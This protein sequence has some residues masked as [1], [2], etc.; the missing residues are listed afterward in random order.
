MQEQ[1]TIAP[2]DAAGQELADEYVPPAVMDLKTAMLNLRRH[3]RHTGMQKAA[4]RVIRLELRKEENRQSVA[5][6][7]LLID[8][9]A[10]IRGHRID[11]EVQEEAIGAVGNLCFDNGD[12][13]SLAGR[14]NL[15]GDVQKAM[16][17]YRGRSSLQ[18]W[19]AGAIRNICSSNTDNKARAGRMGLLDDLY[20]M[21]KRFS[22]HMGIMHNSVGAVRCLVSNED[23]MIVAGKLG[24]LPCLQSAIRSY[25]AHVGIQMQAVGALRA[26]GGTAE[27][28]T[29]AGSLGMLLDIKGMLFDYAWHEIMVDL[30]AGAIWTLCAV[31][32]S[33]KAEAG[34]LG[35]MADLQAV[36]QQNPDNKDIQ[37]SASMACVTLCF[38]SPA[39]TAE[40]KRIGLMQD[41]QGTLLHHTGRAGMTQ[42]R[43]DDP[44]V[45]LNLA[46]E[47]PL[48]VLPTSETEQIMMLEG[49]GDANSSP[50]GTTGSGSP[51]GRRS[52]SPI[53]SISSSG[54]PTPLLAPRG[55]SSK[56]R[57]HVQ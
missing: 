43:N 39:N 46:D 18:E 7:D 47:K 22:W 51:T 14:L 20:L 54:P 23:N 40:A 52:R 13:R 32:T 29:E 2:V 5:K 56:G 36:M 15:L 25:R 24:M 57:Q 44:Q 10:A 42:L 48:M 30:V 50:T 8:L 19:G 34:R 4:A 3:R 6:S 28:S 35:L 17:Q 38:N 9:Q 45:L 12:M 11:V 55:S 37:L 21:M 27:N 53:R 16:A 31:N 33:N 26:M 41:I 1:L 49:G